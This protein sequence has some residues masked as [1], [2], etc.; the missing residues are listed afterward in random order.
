MKVLVVAI[1]CICSAFALGLY[2]FPHSFHS[3]SKQ[4]LIVLGPYPIDP[5]QVSV[6]GISAGGFFAVQYQVAFSSQIIGAGIFAG[7]PYYCKYPFVKVHSLSG[8]S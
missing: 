2:I 7:G 8:G 3:I 1:L 6:G 4:R 5:R